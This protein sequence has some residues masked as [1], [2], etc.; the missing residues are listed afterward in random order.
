MRAAEKIVAALIVGLSV[1]TLLMV[2]TTN[3]QFKGDQ[4]N[5][6]LLVELGSDA[7][8][9]KLAVAAIGPDDRNG[10]AHNTR[11]VLRNTYMDFVFIFLYWLTFVSLAYLA[12]LLGNRL[13]AAISGVLISGAAVLDVLEDTAII[14]AMNVRNFTDAVAVDIW[15]YAQ[16]KWT[17]FFVAIFLLGLAM[18]WNRKVSTLRRACGGVFI[19]SSVV[20]LLGVSRNTASLNFAIWMIDMAVVLIAIA[21]LLTLW[22]LV[23]SVRELDHVHESRHA[24][25]HA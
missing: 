5:R 21:L 17:L 7:E 18:A 6:I 19:A 3:R 4:S 20:G 13:L 9:L 23:K 24:Q 15:E 8:S 14:T 2:A 22:K 25:A 12:G 16:S 10:I 1:W 11:L